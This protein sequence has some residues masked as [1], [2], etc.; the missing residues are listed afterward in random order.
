MILFGRQLKRG[1]AGLARKTL[2]GLARMIVMLGAAVF[3][4]A[5]SLSYTE[6][7][8]FLAIFFF[9][10]SSICAYLW[11][12]D[13]ALLKRRL[14]R[15]PTDEKEARQKIIHGLL[16]LC[17]SASI[18]VSSFDRRFDWSSVPEIWPLC[19]DAL[20]LAGFLVIFLVLRANSFAGATIEVVRGQAV[21]A[22]GPYALVR[23]PLYSGAVLLFA[24]IAPALGSLWGSLLFLPII[25]L[26]A[27]RIHEEEK[28]LV[29]RLS[30]YAAYRRKTPHRLF[31]GVW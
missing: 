29:S 16:S 4:P 2:R 12:Y 17:F 11:Y 8:T 19:G 22:T 3:L 18:I 1:A 7:W 31:P 21:I 15:H 27:W 28:L 23:H 20:L 13:P 9:C 24:G 26:L 30:G 10:A 6:G 14:D 5:W 25:P